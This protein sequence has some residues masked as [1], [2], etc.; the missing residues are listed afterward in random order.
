M[1]THTMSRRQYETLKKDG[2]V[3]MVTA[4]PTHDFQRY[5]LTTT[6]DGTRTGRPRN[7]VAVQERLGEGKYLMLVLMLAGVELPEPFETIDSIANVVNR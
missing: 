4:R 1:K 2:G 6:S 3:Q 5:T 7:R